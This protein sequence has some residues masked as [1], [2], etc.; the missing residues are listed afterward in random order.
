MVEQEMPK[1]LV[2]AAE[3]DQVIKSAA[4]KTFFKIVEPA[5]TP[6]EQSDHDHWQMTSE[7]EMGN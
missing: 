1:P 4:A 7:L 3:V 6:R 5:M 2:G